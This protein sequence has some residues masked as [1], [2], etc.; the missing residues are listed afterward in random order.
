MKLTLF[1][2]Y[3]TSLKIWQ[4]TGLLEREIQI[5]KDLNCKNIE[6]QFLTYGDENDL[7]IIPK[8][9]IEV[10][11]IYT[12]MRKSK[13]KILNYIKS[14]FIPFFFSRELSESQIYKTNQMWGSWVA[15][16]SKLLFK[17]KLIVRCGYELLDFSLK[18]KKSKFYCFVVFL[19]SY[20]A[21]KYCDKI[22]VSSIND[23]KFIKDRYKINSEKITLSPNWVDTNKFK[24]L[25]KRKEKKIIFIGRLTY[26]KNLELIIDA[27]SNTFIQLDVYGTGHKK[28]ELVKLSERKNSKVFFKGNIP[29][30]Q[31][32]LII[33]KYMLFVL[34]SHFEG[35]P[36]SLLEAMSCE[37]VVIGKNSPGIKEVIQDEFTGLVINNKLDLLKAIYRTFN[38]KELRKRLSKNARNFIINNHS[39]E[40]ALEQEYSYLNNIIY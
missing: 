22:R 1:F 14:L 29:N 5:Y 27:L 3:G 40:T 25:K 16:L 37:S 15:I 17:K 32:P 9:G 31:L 23:K 2:T 26:Q 39:Y 12:K 28:N 10:I 4:E 6:V 18:E 38:D 19:I 8:T 11:P 34:P 24:K 33:N 20:I 30:D 21:Y 7:C 36:K 35:T 13:S